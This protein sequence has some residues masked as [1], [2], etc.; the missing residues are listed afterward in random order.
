M[1]SWKWRGRGDFWIMPFP[2]K[3]NERR[4][5][6]GQRGGVCKYGNNCLGHAEF[7]VPETYMGRKLRANIY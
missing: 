1:I 3:G 7:E 5:R 4:D 6:M 2:E